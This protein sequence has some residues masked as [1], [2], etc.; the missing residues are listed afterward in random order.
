MAFMST[1]MCMQVLSDAEVMY[2]SSENTLS[3]EHYS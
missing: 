1:C 2:C 3:K